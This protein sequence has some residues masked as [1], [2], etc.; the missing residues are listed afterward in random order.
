LAEI[1]ALDDVF[2]IDAVYFFFA[3]GE[4]IFFVY[5]CAP[6]PLTPCAADWCERGGR[7]SVN[8]HPNC[9]FL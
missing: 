6:R 3:E 2:V 5:P 8:L 4:T 1:F 7:V 9:L